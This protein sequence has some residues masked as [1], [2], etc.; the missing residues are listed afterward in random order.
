VA[1]NRSVAFGVLCSERC[2]VRASARFAGASSSGFLPSSR[3]VAAGERVRFKLRLG[4]KA[5]KG[6][7]RLAGRGKRVRVRVDVT[8][9]DASGNKVTRTRYVVAV[10]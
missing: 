9:R 7:R 5:L 6:V 2:T 8:A 3:K 1:H 10:P 4:Q